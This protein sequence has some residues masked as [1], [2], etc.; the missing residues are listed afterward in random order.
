MNMLVNRWDLT[1]DAHQATLLDLAARRYIE[2]RTVD[3]LGFSSRW[4]GP[5]AAGLFAAAGITIGLAIAGG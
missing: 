4:F 5:L 2:F 1:R 3:R